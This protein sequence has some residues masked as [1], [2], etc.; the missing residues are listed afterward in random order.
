MT[1][2]YAKDLTKT[3]EAN[4]AVEEIRANYRSEND[5]VLFDI[6]ETIGILRKS[7]TGWTREL[8][9]VSWNGSTP[10][11]DIRDWDPMHEKMGRGI[12]FTKA[13]ADQICKW[14]AVRGTQLGRSSAKETAAQVFEADA[15][16]QEVPED[17]V[18]F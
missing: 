17:D 15:A 12:T 9:V 2:E 4:A 7:N 14:L 1:A 13:E 10:R 8:N 6:Q 11:F 3:A 18:P 16:S 5:E